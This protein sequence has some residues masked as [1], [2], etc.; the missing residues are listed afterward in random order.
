MACRKVK[1]VPVGDAVL[2]VYEPF[3]LR[4]RRPH[5]APHH[6]NGTFTHVIN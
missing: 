3:V 1:E 4:T 5:N 6:E 2:D